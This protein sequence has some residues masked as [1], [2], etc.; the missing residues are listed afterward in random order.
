MAILTQ[1]HYIHT[2]GCFRLIPALLQQVLGEIKLRTNKAWY[3]EHA[4]YTS[5]V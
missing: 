4:T 1:G 5:I 3:N 2:P